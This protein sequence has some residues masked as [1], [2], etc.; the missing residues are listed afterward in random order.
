MIAHLLDH[1][2]GSP[3]GPGN[4]E[5]LAIGT[6]LLYL[7]RELDSRESLHHDIRH[8]KFGL[9]VKGR[10]TTKMRG[11]GAVVIGTAVKGD[12]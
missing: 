12:D 7:Y 9:S 10:R 2:M 1:G 11:L 5:N 3:D 8:E 6:H 4:Q